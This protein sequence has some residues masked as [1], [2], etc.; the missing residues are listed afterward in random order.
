MELV[1]DYFLRYGILV[2]FIIVFLEYMNFPGLASGPILGG[3]GV[4]SSK[5]ILSFLVAI[6][7]CIISGVLASTV[8]YYIGYFGGN[9]LM[10]KLIKKFP[11]LKIGFE[12][13]NCFNDKGYKRIICRFLPAVRTLAPMVEGTT[14]LRFRSFFI[15]SVLGISVYNIIMLL[16]GYLFG[17]I[18]F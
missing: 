9:K 10:N 1:L 7:I 13:V 15:S 11:K 6:L 5:G 4:L 12:K 16:S 8:L 2:I 3:I 17:E 18:L 14:R